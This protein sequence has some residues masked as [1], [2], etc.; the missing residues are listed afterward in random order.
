[1]RWVRVLALGVDLHT[2]PQEAD[3]RTAHLLICNKKLGLDA[4]RSV[5]DA[6]DRRGCTAGGP[7]VWKREAERLPSGS[8]L[9][10]PGE[11]QTL[12]VPLLLFGRLVSPVFPRVGTTVW[13]PYTAPAA[14]PGRRG[15]AEV[16]VARC[17]RV[18]DRMRGVQHLPAIHS[19]RV[20]SAKRAAL[21]GRI[22]TDLLGL[23]G[24]VEP[25]PLTAA[26]F[27]SGYE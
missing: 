15:D 14:P 24:S 9:F 23:I 20:G 7:W 19:A 2:R 22:L 1:M 26:A 12:V 17:W 25:V 6:G 10:S 16:A 27:W 4:G 13:T 11:Q 18:D 5:R 21:V 8:G 3:C